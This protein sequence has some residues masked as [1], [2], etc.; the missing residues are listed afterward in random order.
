MG[1]LSLPPIKN[2]RFA[3]LKM[4]KLMILHLIERLCTVALL[5]PFA[6]RSDEEEMR[7][8]RGIQRLFQRLLLLMEARGN[9]LQRYE[10]FERQ[11]SIEAYLERSFLRFV[12]LP[13]EKKRYFYR[14][15]QTPFFSKK[16]LQSLW[17]S[18]KRVMNHIV[19]LSQL[20]DRLELGP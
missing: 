19:F 15:I 17:Y 20:I 5:S 7:R 2:T 10:G 3:L 18:K 4:V 14:I 1:N 6:L 11:C 16:E 9:Y 8:A 12:R 13:S